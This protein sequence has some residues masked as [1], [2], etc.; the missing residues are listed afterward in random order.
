MPQNGKVIFVETGA[1]DPDFNLRREP[2]FILSAK[3]KNGVV[4]AS[5]IERH[6]EY[7]PTVE[8]TKGS[9]TQV[10]NVEHFRFGTVDYIRV[11]SKSGEFVG[12]A[13]A[14]DGSEDSRH[15]IEIDGKTISWRGPYFLVNSQ[16]HASQGEL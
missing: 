14:Q 9:H 16:K 15:S 12:L 11:T 2:G 13:I 3:T 6:G 5:V 7:N 1:S 8:Y 10:K 4:F